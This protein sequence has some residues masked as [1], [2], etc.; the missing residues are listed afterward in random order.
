[1]T[2]GIDTDFNTLFRVVILPGQINRAITYSNHLQLWDTLKGKLLKYKGIQGLK[3]NINSISFD[4][5]E[6]QVVV[7]GGTAESSLVIWNI[8]TD[9]TTFV[10]HI[11]DN[12]AS[13]YLTVN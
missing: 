10:K 4:S 2:K 9:Q 6:Q 11:D 3:D 7:V 8:N 13:V 1:M 5:L 12:D